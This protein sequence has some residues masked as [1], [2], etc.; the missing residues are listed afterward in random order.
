MRIAARPI[1][2]QRFSQG[3][4]Q[5]Y[6]ACPAGLVTQ[7]E[8]LANQQLTHLGCDQRLKFPQVVTPHTV[9]GV[10]GIHQFPIPCRDLVDR[11]IHP[12]SRVALAQTAG[13]ALPCL[14]IA[15]FHV[16]QCPIQHLA[17]ITGS[18]VQHRRGIAGHNM[19][20]KITGQIREAPDRLAGNVD[21]IAPLTSLD[22]DG[23]Y[24]PRMQG[25]SAH[26]S[27]RRLALTDL[28]IGIP[29]TEGAHPSQAMDGFQ[30]TGLARGIGAGNEI[31]PGRER[32]LCCLD[33]AVIAYVEGQESRKAVR[34]KI[35]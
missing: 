18:T 24:P 31:E 17:P 19:H 26:Q 15:R 33:I 14:A 10:A 30:Q 27:E 5:G 11:R 21:D 34:R 22:A 13:I 8:F 35:V 16:E 2:I 28:P 9:Q 4:L 23:D 20:G 25:N 7:G 29:G 6:V 1:R 32:Q 12:E 3:F